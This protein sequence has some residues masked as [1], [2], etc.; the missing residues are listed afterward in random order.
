VIEL[1][2]R[3][4]FRYSNSLNNLS[5]KLTETYNWTLRGNIVL[6]LPYDVTLNSDI[7]YSNRLGYSNF[8]Q[9]ELLWNASI[10][11]SLFKNKGVLSVKWFDI[12]HQQLNIRQT[13]GDNS[14]TF[15]RYNTLTSYFIVSFS[16]RIRQF[17]GRSTEFNSRMRDGQFGPGMRPEG[18]PGV[19]PEGGGYRRTEGGPPH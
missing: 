11:K 8:D 18:G 12:L 9:S 10:D 2:G 3:G 7:N 14:V 16:Y 1:G 6:R 15:A 19:R 17:G 4:V 5:N 13:V